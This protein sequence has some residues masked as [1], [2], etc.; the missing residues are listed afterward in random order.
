MNQKPIIECV[1]NF[2]EGR[3]PE[4]I[5]QIART[6]ESVRGVKLLNIDPG[7]STNRTVIT[8]AGA[9]EDVIEA[10]FQAIRIASQLIDMR[11]HK[12][13][14][15]RMGATDVCPL[16]PISGIN[17]EETAV[18][19]KKL[20]ERVGKELKIPVYLYEAAA[21]APHRRNLAE[22]RSGEYEGFAEKMK[23]KAW[24]PD[25]G[26]SEF[27]VL[28]GA[29]VIGAR[30]FLIAYNVNLNSKSVRL[31]NEVAYDIRENGRPK[32]D[33]ETQKLLKNE[34]GE[35]ERI[36]GSC[37]GVK[38]IG[39]YIEEYGY[40]QI[41]MNLTD[42]HKTP[43]HIA[44]EECR[45]SAEQYGLIVTGSELVGLVPKKALID[46]GKYFL[47]KQKRSLGVT[48]EEL[49]QI[50]I[51][52]LGL[53]SVSVFLPN[54]RII[55]NMLED[56][57]FP[58][59]SLSLKKFAEETASDSP[60]PGGGSVSAYAATMGASLATMVANLTAH[61]KGYEDKLSY[62][63]EIASKGMQLSKELLELVDEDTAAF[64]MIMEAFRLPKVTPEDKKARKKAI[65]KATI[66]AI[67]VP[68]K[69][70]KLASL[71]MPLAKAMVENGNP[72][73]ISDAG[74]GALCLEAA[75][76]GA[77]LNVKINASG[78]EDQDLKK[79][80]F[81]EADEYVKSAE[82]ETK[83]VLAM[84]NEFISRS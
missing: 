5:Q 16:I 33:P 19:A 55:E 61:K 60:A 15:P 48:E 8:F 20:G 66:V 28:A 14:H 32:R 62:F 38:A 39:W 57:K 58:L 10:A 72:N 45:R 36:P 24:K 35:I 13:E 31:A 68:L 9:P 3:N 52:S 42:L 79:K 51:Q 29:T 46:C 70:I 1:P 27:N 50:A 4:I 44:F 43:L 82:E 22:I 40:A 41:S 71:A 77:A 75:I 59:A 11:Q 21:S 64:N 47:N 84:V 56:K 2:S 18:Y 34:S 69:T 80:Y 23:Q 63:S 81:E 30:D 37:P 73:S 12:G 65:K 78:L 74:V 83:S 6:I 76:K 54:Q 67:E 25:Y 17:L 49:I 7:A 26:P 53:N